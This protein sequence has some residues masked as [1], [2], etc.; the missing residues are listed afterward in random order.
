MKRKDGEVR[1]ILVSASP[2]TSKDGDFEGTQAIITDITERVK[3]EA[4]L[5]L[6]SLALESAADAIVI[7]DGEGSIQWANPAF[8]S[9]TG[10]SLND[11]IGN[12]PRIL[13]SDLHDEKYYK[14]L[15]DTISAGEVWKG[16]IINKRADGEHYTEEM[17]IT[18][19]V[20]DNKEISNYIAIK[21]DIS[22]RVQSQNGNSSSALRI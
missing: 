4:Q 14:D 10:Y 13:K 2:L 12:N 15:W 9:L 1:T 6:Q 16:E 5:K 3:A 21:H 19:L 22:D 18:P 17:T 7:T 20:S 11:A 8:S